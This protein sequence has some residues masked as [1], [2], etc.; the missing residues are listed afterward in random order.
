MPFLLHLN[1]YAT[2][3]ADTAELSFFTSTMRQV[4][5]IMSAYFS[6]CGLVFLAIPRAE[7]HMLTVRLR[8]L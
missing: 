2:I 7:S 3:P 8:I 6:K 1:I 5:F 4:P